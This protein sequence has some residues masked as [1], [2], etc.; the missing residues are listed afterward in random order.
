MCVDE[1]NPRFKNLKELLNKHIF[2]IFDVDLRLKLVLRMN[3]W[4]TTKNMWRTYK[5]IQTYSKEF[6]WLFSCFN[7]KLLSWQHKKQLGKGIIPSCKIHMVEEETLE[8]G[9][10]SGG[11]EKL[12]EEEWVLLNT[13]SLKKTKIWQNYSTS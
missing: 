13:L 11:K 1:W 9:P 2:H 5:N 12:G 8:R 4:W 10:K 7:L 3:M 6:K